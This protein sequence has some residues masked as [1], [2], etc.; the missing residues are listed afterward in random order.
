MMTVWADDD[1]RTSSEEV[2]R[3]S[4]INNDENIHERIEDKCTYILHTHV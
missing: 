2:V 4:K 1:V 3:T